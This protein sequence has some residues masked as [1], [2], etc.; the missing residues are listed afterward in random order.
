MVEDASSYTRME[1]SKN[2]GGIQDNSAK[3]SSYPETL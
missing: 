2:L 1:G 3:I